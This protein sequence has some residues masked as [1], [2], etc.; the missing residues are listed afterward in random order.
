MISLSFKSARE[1]TDLVTCKSVA[2][3]TAQFRLKLAELM[4]EKSKYDGAILKKEFKDFN[5]LLLK[6]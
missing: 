6:P 4:T 5:L 1:L 3:G 2:S